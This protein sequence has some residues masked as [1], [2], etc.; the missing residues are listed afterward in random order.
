MLR[1]N[2]GQVALLL[3]QFGGDHETIVVVAQGDHTSHSGPGLYAALE[4]YPDEGS[5]FLGDIESAGCPCND[6]HHDR[7]LQKALDKLEE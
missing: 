3:E 5:V 1:F 4:D 7:K 2:L 6:C